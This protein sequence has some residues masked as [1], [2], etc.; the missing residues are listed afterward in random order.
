MRTNKGEICKNQRN[1]KCKLLCIFWWAMSDVGNNLVIYEWKFIL[2]EIINNFFMAYIYT[3]S[4]AYR[5]LDYLYIVY[6]NFYGIY[7]HK[8]TQ[9]HT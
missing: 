8:Y 2:F 9:T 3:I 1:T 7:I 4:C 6:I 5:K